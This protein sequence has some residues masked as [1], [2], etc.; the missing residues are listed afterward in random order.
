MK[1][2]KLSLPLGYS[3]LSKYFDALGGGSSPLHNFLIWL[4]LL[5]QFKTV[6]YLGIKI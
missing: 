5:T 1:E 4:N 2:N 6:K 3:K